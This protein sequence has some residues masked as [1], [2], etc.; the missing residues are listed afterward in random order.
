MF[1]TFGR[2]I[3]VTSGVSQKLKETVCFQSDLVCTLL[4]TRNLSGIRFITAIDI[5]NFL[6]LFIP[7]Y[8]GN[9]QAP[10]E[11]LV[12]KILF[13][14]YILAKLVVI[15]GGVKDLR[16]VLFIFIR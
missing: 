6:N 11:N 16:T 4:I 14:A 12:T 13:A 3:L 2:T 9:L 5:D 15:G 7:P 1:K 8:F 10:C